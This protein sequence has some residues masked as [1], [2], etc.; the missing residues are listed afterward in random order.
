[1]IKLHCESIK[2]FKDKTNGSRRKTNQ[3]P[4]RIVRIDV[5]YSTKKTFGNENEESEKVNPV[6]SIVIA[7]LRESSSVI[8]C[9]R[10]ASIKTPHN[11]KTMRP[12]IFHKKKAKI[13]PRGPARLRAVE[14]TS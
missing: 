2:S 5:L 7:S 3:V 6:H 12:G 10:T 13:P 8:C 14:I 9:V 11:V 1:M 4:R